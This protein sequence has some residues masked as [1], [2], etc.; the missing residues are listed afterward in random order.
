MK[1]GKQIRKLYEV[2]FPKKALKSQEEEIYSQL[3]TFLSAR[4]AQIVSYEYYGAM[5]MVLT[6]QYEGKNHRCV[7]DRG[8]IY[9]NDQLASYSIYLTGERIDIVTKLINVITEKLFCHN[10]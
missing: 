5:G 6:F 3:H 9:I 8:E 4:N 10:P 1:K 2:L 7:V